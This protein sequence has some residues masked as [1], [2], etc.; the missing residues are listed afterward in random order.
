MLGTADDLMSCANMFYQ[1]PYL[2]A[3]SK[4]FKCLLLKSFLLNHNYLRTN[5]IFTQINS[6]DLKKRTLNVF[7]FRSILKQSLTSAFL[8]YC[9]SSL[10]F[11]CDSLSKFSDIREVIKLDGQSLFGDQ[12]QLC[13][14]QKQKN[15]LLHSPHSSTNS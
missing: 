10:A 3:K 13:T 11:I 9:I 15:N 4:A 8:L 1:D 14:N 6:A 7:S 2:A 5:R 12:R